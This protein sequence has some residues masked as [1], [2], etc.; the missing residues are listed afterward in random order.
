MTAASYGFL[1]M[2]LTH[3][4]F[5]QFVRLLV[6]FLHSYLEPNHNNQ[7]MVGYRWTSEEYKLDWRQAYD[8]W[9][10]LCMQTE[11]RR[12][13]LCAVCSHS[14][15]DVSVSATS[16]TCSN[17]LLHPRDR[18]QSCRWSQSHRRSCPFSHQ[19]FLPSRSCCSPLPALRGRAS[20]HT[21]R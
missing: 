10:V 14:P 8:Y 7:D 17:H 9:L 18:S 1:I 5:S 15:S 16:A 12:V 11:V 2:E 3:L 19:P 20:C 21:T 13:N 6:H 4:L